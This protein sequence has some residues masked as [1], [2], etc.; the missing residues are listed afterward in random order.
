MRKFII[1]LSILIVMGLSPTL[2]QGATPV[3]AVTDLI[4]GGAGAVR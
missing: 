1:F 2:V 3:M 4:G